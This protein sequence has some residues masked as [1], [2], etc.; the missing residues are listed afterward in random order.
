M[1]EALPA[2]GKYK[3]DTWRTLPVKCYI[4]NSVRLQSYKRNVNRKQ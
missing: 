3:Y 2:S 1:I 4:S